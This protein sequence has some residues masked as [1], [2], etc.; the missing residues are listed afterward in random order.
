MVIAQAGRRARQPSRSRSPLSGRRAG[1]RT[2]PRF[3]I[4]R[5]DSAAPVARA[6]RLSGR[7]PVAHRHAAAAH[8]PTDAATCNRPHPPACCLSLSV[9]WWASHRIAGPSC[10]ATAATATPTTRSGHACLPRSTRAPPTS[11][12][13]FASRSLEPKVAAARTSRPDAGALKQP[14]ALRVDRSDV[15]CHQIFRAAAAPPRVRP[16]VAHRIVPQ[17]LDCGPCAASS[18]SAGVRQFASMSLPRTISQS[19]RLDWPT[20]TADPERTHGLAASFKKKTQRSSGAARAHALA[21]FH[22]FRHGAL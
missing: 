8:A 15:Q 18:A 11:T 14:Y 2:A 21:S 6:S 19:R 10:R 12:P 22:W 1:E 16:S 9:S 5:G 13:S 17:R 7:D 3:R 20:R 4:R